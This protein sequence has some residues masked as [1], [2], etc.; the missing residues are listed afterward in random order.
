MKYSKGIFYGL[1]SFLILLFINSGCNIQKRRYSNGFYINPISHPKENIHHQI[2]EVENKN[3]HKTLFQKGGDEK[4][5]IVSD[6][7]DAKDNTIPLNSKIYRKTKYQ[8]FFIESDTIPKKSNSHSPLAT[9]KPVKPKL[10]VFSKLA[11]IAFLISFAFTIAIIWIAIQFA[12]PEILVLL[13]LLN[14]FTP[15]VGFLLSIEGNFRTKKNPEK[16]KSVSLS[17][18]IMLYSV[19][20]F[21]LNVF[22]FTIYIMA[23]ASAIV[24]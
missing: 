24:W 21:L 22:L 23:L 5:V 2:N 11:L 3:T 19:L 17:R 20:L 13:L 12:L 1:L 4:L 6:T 15:I 18:I 16:F 8:Q 10:E 7:V 9:T 14:I